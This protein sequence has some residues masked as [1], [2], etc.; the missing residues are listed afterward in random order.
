MSTVAIV[1]CDRYEYEKVEKA[2]RL[3][4][5]LIGNVKEK[6]KP[7]NKVLLKPN[8]LMA[9]T[10][11]SAVTTHPH[12][13]KAMIKIVKECGAIPFVGDNPGNAYANVQRALETTG[14]RD[15]AKE[16]GA[17]ILSLAKPFKCGDIYVASSIFDIDLIINLPKL[18]THNLTLF[19]G[20]IKNMF[21][22]MPGFH[23][24][25]MHR[26]YPYPADF[27]AKLV[28]IFSVKKPVLGIM[29]AV[30]GMEG[31]GPSGGK[32]RRIGLILASWDCVSLDAVC[33]KI[34]GYEPFSV[35]TTRIAHQRG[36]GE[37]NL[38][39]IEIRGEKLQNVAISDFELA[40]NAY[41]ILKGVPRFIYPPFQYLARK[42]IW[43]RPEVI[44]EKCTG[45]GICFK[46]CPV[47]AISMEE[48]KPRIDYRKCISCYCCH[49]LCPEK[50]YEIKR[51]WLAR[52]WA[53]GVQD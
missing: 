6:I 44:K 25:D 52:K 9:A 8:M 16:E 7:G 30:Y 3:A 21:G 10:P 37:G 35:D 11:D 46:N 27:S 26:R 41:K 38:S 31:H 39:R 42:L 22:I 33:S 24:G 19:T 45:C 53:I 36:L 1:K 29:D 51:S 50:A 17:E 47:K 49:E 15:V 13:L 4:L 48:G 14:Y 40:D 2:V 20:C 12:I 32:P 34:I 28:D 43:V 5:S 18:K 23:K